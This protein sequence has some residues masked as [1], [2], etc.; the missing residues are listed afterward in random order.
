MPDSPTDRTN[1]CPSTTCRLPR[2]LWRCVR[3]ISWDSRSVYPSP[4]YLTS[5]RA[6]D[7][8]VA[9]QRHGTL[10]AAPLGGHPQV[11]LLP[12]VK[13]GDR[14]EIH[15]VQAD[16]TFRALVANP[17]VTFLVSDFLAF[18]PH[19]WVDPHDAGRATLHFR[20]VAFACEATYSTDPAD[21]A[22]ALRRLL[23]AYEPQASYVAMENGEFYGAR[24]RRLAAVQLAI[25]ER[26]AKF[27]V[28][29]AAPPDDARERVAAGLRARDDPGDL[30]AAAIIEAALTE[31]PE[32]SD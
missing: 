11:S 12:F 15:C 18:S 13:D 14:I 4:R 22:G 2:G 26:Q 19:D 28:G 23:A 30:R 5:R 25:V 20:A 9:T 6:A 27:K 8:F 17:H 10:I 7:R 32:S 24:L 16:P 3:W 1:P 31:P 21:V 29:P